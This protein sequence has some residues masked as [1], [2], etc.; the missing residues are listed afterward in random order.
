MGPFSLVSI[1]A[2]LAFDRHGVGS[3]DPSGILKV[4]TRGDTE[5]YALYRTDT[6]L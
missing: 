6:M 5:K 1:K 2:H 4:F 3:N